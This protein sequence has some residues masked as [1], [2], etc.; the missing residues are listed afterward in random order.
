MRIVLAILLLGVVGCVSDAGY[1]TEARY[2][3]NGVGYTDAEWR[4]EVQK[5]GVQL[6]ST[7]HYSDPYYYNTNR[8]YYDSYYY[9][10]STYGPY[11]HRSYRHRPDTSYRDDDGERVRD[12]EQQRDSRAE[13]RYP[14]R[15]AIERRERPVERNNLDD[16]PRGVVGDIERSRDRDEQRE[17]S[18]SD[19]RVN[20]DES[21]DRSRTESRTEPRGDRNVRDVE[22][23]RRAAPDRSGASGSE[24]SGDRVRRR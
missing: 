11:R 9:P 13:T 14:E 7:R 3:D 2:Y 20:R 23:I 10:G 21:R 6:E 18:R 19:A 15:R 16:R 12:R 22:N 1:D 17:R 24:Q 5:R 4:Y 8:Y